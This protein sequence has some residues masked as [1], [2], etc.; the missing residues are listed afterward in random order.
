[1]AAE[2]TMLPLG[3]PLPD[4]TL[5]DADGALHGPSDH[6][7]A[8]GVLV[9]FV[10]NHCPYVKHVA[11]EL[12]RL[13]KGWIDRG[14]AVIAVNPNDATAY[15]EDA[16]ELMPG[17][18]VANG[19]T[20]PYLYDEAQDVARTYQA[21]CTPDFF[22]FDGDHQLAYRGRFDASRPGSA[23]PLTGEDLATAVDAVLSG[24]PVPTPQLPSIGCSI[25]WK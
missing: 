23:T 21:A 10:C 20:F 9:A 1:M 22:L 24:D 5:P 7:D 17:F 13:A 18:A 3:T 12:G 8:P 6:P 4:F 11:P 16:P 19:W 25:K 15:P 14:L 2:S